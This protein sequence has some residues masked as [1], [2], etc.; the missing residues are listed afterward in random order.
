MGMLPGNVLTPSLSF[1]FSVNFS[2]LDEMLNPKHLTLGSN[3]TNTG[4]PTEIMEVKVKGG[5]SF[6][7]YTTAAATDIHVKSVEVVLRAYSEQGNIS[8]RRIY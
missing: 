3:C 6:L 2:V 8:S 5:V 1:S 7:G 4:I